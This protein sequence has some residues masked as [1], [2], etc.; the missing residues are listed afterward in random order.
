MGSQV[1]HHIPANVLQVTWS[2]IN[3]AQQAEC[4]VSVAV[5]AVVNDIHWR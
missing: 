2:I 3:R 1:V 5:I 4:P